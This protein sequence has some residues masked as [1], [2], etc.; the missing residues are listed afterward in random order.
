MA[1]INFQQ[2]IAVV[3]R[4]YS[5]GICTAKSKMA[6]RRMRGTCPTEI[7]LSRSYSVLP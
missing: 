7:V 1:K 2:I 4:A 3:E 6:V 5:I